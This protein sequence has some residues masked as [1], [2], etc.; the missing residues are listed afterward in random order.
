MATLRVFRTA[1]VLVATALVATATAACV[2]GGTDVEA[3]VTSPP[4][5][6]SEAPE[7]TLPLPVQSIVSV[8]GVDP[9]GTTVTVSGYAAGVV[10]DDGVCRFDIQSMINPEI[11]VSVE[12]VGMM[13]AANTSCGAT[14]I[15]MSEFTPGTWSVTLVYTSEH[16]KATSEPL[17]LEI[18]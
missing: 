4:A 10:E 6:G 1:A 15:P 17:D 2:S 3:P 12:T 13:D 5:A 9:D 8:A 18:P 7:T 16:A 14:Q 11:V